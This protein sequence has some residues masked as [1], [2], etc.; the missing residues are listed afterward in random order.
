MY[1]SVDMKLMSHLEIKESRIPKYRQ[2][3]DGV[4]EG[5]TNGHLQIDEKIPS[6]N[7][8]SESYGLSRDTVEKAY[9]ILKQRKVITSVKG[10]G[11][12]ITRTPLIGKINVLFLINKLST[13]KMQIYNAFVKQIGTSAHVDLHVYHC[14]E[15]LFLNLLKKSAAV[16]DHIVVMPHFKSSSSR[17]VSATDSVERALDRIAASK[18]LLLDNNLIRLTHEHAEVYQDFEA[19][20]YTALKEGH[21]KIKR[22]SKAILVYPMHAIYPYPKRILH[23]FRRFCSEVRLPFEVIDEVYEDTVLHEGDLFITIAETD[24]VNLVKQ[25]RDKGLTVGKDIGIIS[26]ND[27][28]LKDLLGITVMS[29]DFDTM[30]S[31][32]ARLVIEKRIEQVQNPF[33]LIERESL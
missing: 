28:P 33:R 5:V 9:N 6:I 8:L 17:H 16:Y 15:S 21:D 24:L 19:D 30:G 13:Y 12:Y 31:T 29:T 1:A 10:K 4:I 20:I 18:V 25:V 26:Y 3:V 14:D 22:Y 23:G 2:I 27:T 32:A 7:A 11:F